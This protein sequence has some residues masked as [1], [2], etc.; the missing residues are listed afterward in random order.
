MGQCRCSAL[1]PLLATAFHR[2]F[3]GTRKYGSH[4]QVSLQKH[5]ELPGHPLDKVVLLRLE[6]TR[7]SD[8]DVEQFLA[9]L[10]DTL[11]VPHHRLVVEDVWGRQLNLG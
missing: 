4:I 1:A 3:Q 7:P 8:L 9:E 10:A 2:H 11:S 6:G 5:Y